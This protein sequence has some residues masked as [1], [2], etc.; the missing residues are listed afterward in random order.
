M[1]LDKYYYDL[2]DDQIFASA[3][4]Y[5]DVPNPFKEH[6]RT[7]CVGKTVISR[8]WLNLFDLI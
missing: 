2:I 4:C 5:D 7:I 1:F 6:F 3:L 8:I